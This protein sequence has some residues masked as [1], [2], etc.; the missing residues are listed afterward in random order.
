MGLTTYK[1]FGHSTNPGH[2]ISLP[3]CYNKVLQTGDLNHGNLSPLSLQTG[4]LKARSQLGLL[5]LSL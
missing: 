2:C 5:L 4:I 1:S 3:V